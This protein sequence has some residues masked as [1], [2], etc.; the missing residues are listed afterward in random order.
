MVNIKQHQSKILRTG[1]CEVDLV[2][3]AQSHDAVKQGQSSLA[4]VPGTPAMI[5]RAY[6]HTN[7]SSC[8]VL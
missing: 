4:C 3:F 6:I 5:L 8:S 7:E 2:R 1:A